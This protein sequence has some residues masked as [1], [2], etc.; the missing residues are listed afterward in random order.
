MQVLKDVSIEFPKGK[1][2][3]VVGSSGCGKTT[4]IKVASGL[5]GE[6]REGYLAGTVL[7]SGESP[8]SLRSRGSLGF[9]FQDY[10]LLPYMSVWENVTWPWLYASQSIKN[11]IDLA[12]R[13]KE[14]LRDVG[15]EHVR[16]HRP[17]E[18]SGGMK[19]RVALARALLLKPKV[20][21]IDEVLSPLDV[22]WRIDL[23]QKLRAICD[24]QGTTLVIVSHDLDGIVD[25]SDSFFVLGEFGEVKLKLR[26]QDIQSKEVL[27]GKIREAILQSHPAKRDYL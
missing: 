17:S 1:I 15:L 2:S 13:G 21:F 11:R 20:V 10:S 8:R 18:L 24:E 22:G 14:M 23:S 12:E 9:V 3:C 5:L 7:I 27:R 26:R 4:L 19:A 16:D 25:V 6:D